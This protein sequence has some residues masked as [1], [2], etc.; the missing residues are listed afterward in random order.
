MN[1][2]FQIGEMNVAVE[3]TISALTYKFIPRESAARL[4]FP[5]VLLLPLVVFP[6]GLLGLVVYAST[7]TENRPLWEE[8]LAGVFAAQ[9]L[10]WLLLGIVESTVMLRWTMFRSNTTLLRF[11]QT[12][13]WHSGDRVCGLEQVR[14]LRLFVYPAIEAESNRFEA[15]LSLVIGDADSTHGLFGGFE[16]E[17]L[18]T[19]AEDIQQSL[20]RFR[21][22]Q[23]IM[24]VFE[25][26]SVIETTADKASELM[27]T[28]PPASGFRLF[29]T[30][31]LL[32]LWNRWVGSLWCIAMFAGLFATGHLVLATK[33]PKTILFGHALVGFVHAAMLLGIWAQ[34]DRNT[35]VESSEESH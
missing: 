10:V 24:A 28:R 35:T 19:L 22:N 7:R 26:L 14:G 15:C 3:E 27:H 31:G 8:I 32:L 1:R 9:M 6:A 4:G 21:A 11:T 5:F 17:Q 16:Q 25:A 30:A 13:V 33:L 29:A 23:G 18:R 2:D 20:T 12:Q 34:P